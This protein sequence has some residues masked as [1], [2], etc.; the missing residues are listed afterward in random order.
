MALIDRLFTDKPFLGSRRIS[1]MLKNDGHDVNRK[2]VQRLMR[3]MGL[4]AIH[5]KVKTSK[6]DPGHKKYPYLLR[7]LKIEEAN[8]VWCSDITYIPMNRGWM[9]LVAVM[10]WASRFV[11]SWELS[12][13]MD[14]LFCSVAVEN[15]LEVNKP[16]IFNTD[17][18]VQ[19]T[20]NSFQRILEDAQVQI[21][22]DGKGRWMDNVF[23]ERL[24]RSVK[25]EE[26]YL[27]EYQTVFELRSRLN[28]WFDFYNHKRPHQ[29]LGYQTPAQV[30]MA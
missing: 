21:S 2:R 24:W 16:R 13:T 22:M 9:Y 4:E 28:A 5:P 14:V 11:L 10:D 3:V 26:V 12:N 27:N 1:Q 15:A 7:G 8:H 17:Q 30:Y 19:F 18:G 6:S 25:Y 20:S 29:A 23:I